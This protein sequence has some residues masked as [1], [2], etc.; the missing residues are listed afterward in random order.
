MCVFNKNI[1]C[2]FIASNKT[3]LIILFFIEMFSAI[4]SLLKP[5]H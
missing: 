4:M 3:L 1:R 5:V 2:K